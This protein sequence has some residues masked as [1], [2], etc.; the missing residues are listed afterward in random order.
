SQ[1]SS[2]AAGMLGAQAEMHQDGPLFQLARRS[3]AMF[4]SLAEELL[5]YSGM[6]IGFETKGTMK[7]AITAEEAVQLKWFMQVQHQ[8]GG[9]AEWLSSA[10]LKA[11]ETALTADVLGA[12]YM[13]QEGHVLAPELTLAYARSA[14]ALGAEI[15]EFT[16]VHSLLFDQKRLCGVSTQNGAI[17]GKHVMIASGVWS[18]S[19]LEQIGD[20]MPFYPVKGE[21][22]SVISPKPL[23]NSVVIG[24]HCYLVPKKG[25]RTIVGATMVEHCFDTKVSLGG[26][27]ILLEQAAQLVPVILQAE[28]EKSWA[29]LRPQTIDGLPF[30]GEHEKHKGLFIAAGH[31]RNGILLSPAT[32]EAMADLLMKGASQLNLG[33][34]AFRLE[35]L[36]PQ[37]DGSNKVR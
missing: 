20:P 2:A 13:P 27:R 18:G 16:E 30:M 3:R 24:P 29:G 8:L 36:N 21:C 11:K 37:K 28:W 6:D 34:E 31:Y 5:E 22:F 9:Q 23:L 32:G 35:R 25:G 12:V 10:Q 26:I 4:P 19:L 15:R 17:T 1:A 33:L 14:E 7:V